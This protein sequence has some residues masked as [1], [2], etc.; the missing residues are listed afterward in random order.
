ME[1]GRLKE[2]FHVCEKVREGSR[3][4]TLPQEVVVRGEGERKDPQKEKNGSVER[5]SSPQC[6][7]IDDVF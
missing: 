3:N 4:S 2:R 7:I 5:S 6:I 1:T